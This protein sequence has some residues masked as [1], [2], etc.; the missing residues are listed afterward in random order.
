M[1]PQCVWRSFPAAAPSKQVCNS[2]RL[3]VVRLSSAPT[4]PTYWLRVLSQRHLLPPDLD[5][6]HSYWLFYLCLWLSDSAK[7]L[8]TP[9]LGLF[10]QAAHRT[11]V[12][13][14][15]CWFIIYIYDTGCQASMPPG[16]CDPPETSAVWLP[17]GSLMLL[18]QFY[19]D[20]MPWAQLLT[21]TW[22]SPQGLSI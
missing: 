2:G 9:Y 6:S 12:N 7:A 3:G 8:S 15:I 16:V 20:F 21:D 14:S 13:P 19:G 10:T 18:L 11:Q 17:G 22:G 1:W 5:A 4:L